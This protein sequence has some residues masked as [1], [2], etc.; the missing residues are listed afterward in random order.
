MRTLSEAVKMDTAN[1]ELKT[2]VTLSVFP[3]LKGLPI[4]RIATD[5]LPT[6]TMGTPKV[7]YQYKTN[8]ITEKPIDV[9]TGVLENDIHKRIVYGGLMSLVAKGNQTAYD[10]LMLHRESIISIE[11]L[12][13]DVLK[14]IMINLATFDFTYEEDK[15][16][17]WL[18]SSDKT[19]DKGL[20]GVVSSRLYS[21]AIRHYRKTYIEIDGNTV[22][23]DDISAL[24]TH[25]NFDHLWECEHIKRFLTWLEWKEEIYFKYR[26]QGYSQRECGE[27]MHVSAS[28]IKRYDRHIKKAYAEYMKTA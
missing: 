2:R 23:L 26:L 27:F 18:H 12:E 7:E 6:P 14:Y 11:D 28:V 21:L 25:V 9:I 15:Q 20:S 8:T 22:R 5:D 10:L 16:G 24:A 17:Y 4:P 13:Q 1:K 19:I 3:C